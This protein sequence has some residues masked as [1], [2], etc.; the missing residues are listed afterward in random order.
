M[1]EMQRDIDLQP[2]FV[3]N[4]CNFTV[5][6]KDKCIAA[7]GLTV[8][9]ARQ[10]CIKSGGESPLFNSFF[11]KWCDY[12]EDFV[13]SLA[14]LRPTGSFCIMSSPSHQSWVGKYAISHLWT[15]DNQGEQRT[16]NQRKV[17]WLLQDGLTLG[18]LSL[19]LKESVEMWRHSSPSLSPSPP[20]MATGQPC[21]RRGLNL[22]R[23]KVNT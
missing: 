1:Q 4:L 11:L 6:N 22:I 17:L 3:R 8:H 20:W 21:V 16:A 10:K 5:F 9:F 19:S 2:S 7:C 12:L 13:I 14:I 15:K 18:R 23:W